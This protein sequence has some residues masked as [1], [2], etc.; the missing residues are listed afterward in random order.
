MSLAMQRAVIFKSDFNAKAVWVHE[1]VYEADDEAKAK[2]KNR[3]EDRSGTLKIVSYLRPIKASGNRAARRRRIGW[4]A[5]WPADRQ[6]VRPV[7]PRGLKDTL[8]LD[9]NEIVG[10]VPKGGAPRWPGGARPPRPDQPDSSHRPVDGRGPEPEA[11]G[12][13]GDAYRCQRT[14]PAGDLQQRGRPHQRPAP[15][16]PITTYDVLR[17]LPFPQE[18]IP[19]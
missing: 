4:P 10:Q 9:P 13:S 15:A 1:C 3:D 2:D 5:G 19:G 7:R 11:R 18:E 16:G 8:Q 12:C 6:V 14:S 17:M